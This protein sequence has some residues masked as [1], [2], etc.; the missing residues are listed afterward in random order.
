MVQ[1]HYPKAFELATIASEKG[2]PNAQYALG[3]CYHYGRGVNCDQNK[4]RKF[5]INAAE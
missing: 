5:Y 4:S 2:Y 1:P 3:L